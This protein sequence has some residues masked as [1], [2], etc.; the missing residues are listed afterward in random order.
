[1]ITKAPTKMSREFLE[2]DRLED[3]AAKP[4]P[5]LPDHFPWALDLPTWE[6]KDAFNNPRNLWINGLGS[7]LRQAA[8]TVQAA[9]LSDK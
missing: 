1:M 6:G 5:L 8:A 2:T 9:D 7:P 4:D 3:L